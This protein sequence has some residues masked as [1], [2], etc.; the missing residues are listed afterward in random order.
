MARPVPSNAEGPSSTST[1]DMHAIAPPLRQRLIYRAFDGL[2]IGAV[3]ELISDSD[4]L[5]LLAELEARCAGA[6]EQHATEA[7][8]LVW[9]VRLRKLGRCDISERLS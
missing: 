4:P 8:P 7:G 6:F 2:P 5:P 9:R 1:L 3:L